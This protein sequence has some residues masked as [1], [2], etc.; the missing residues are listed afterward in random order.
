[1]RPY[2]KFSD[3][4]VG[5]GQETVTVSGKEPVFLRFGPILRCWY[6]ARAAT[7]TSLTL[8]M[9][10]SMGLGKWRQQAEGGPAKSSGNAWNRGLN[11]VDRGL[12]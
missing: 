6:R 10:S 9:P 12:K 1:M 4:D 5:G 3:V 8:M 2:D 11:G 7:S